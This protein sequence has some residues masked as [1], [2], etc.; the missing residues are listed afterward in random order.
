[1]SLSYIAQSNEHQELE[2]IGGGRMSILLDGEATNGQ[3]TVVRSQLRAGAASP[4]HSHQN[5][6]EMFVLLKGDGIFWVGDERHEVGEGGSVFL[7]RDVA[8]A[9]RFVTDVDLL[10]LCTPSGIEG[11]FRGAGRDLKDPRPDGFEITMQAMAA[12][13]IAGGQQILGPP[14]M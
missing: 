8:H 2:W 6:D 14:P 4:L 9:Y 12:A 10:T 5:E 1:M 7:P 13:A 11:F 3:L